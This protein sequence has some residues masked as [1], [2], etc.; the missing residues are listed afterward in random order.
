MDFVEFN[1]ITARP[2]LSPRPLCLQYGD[3]AEIDEDDY[4]ARIRQLRVRIMKLML[5]NGEPEYPARSCKDLFKCYPI[6]PSGELHIPNL[7]SFYSKLHFFLFHFIICINKAP[8]TDVFFFHPL[9]KI[10][11][12][13]RYFN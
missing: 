10:G 8:L 1:V 6:F 12:Q 3:D 4:E 5:P 11:G 9:S 13:F 7:S 2:D